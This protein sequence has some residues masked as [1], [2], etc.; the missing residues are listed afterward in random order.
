MKKKNI[1][2]TGSSSEIGIQ[3]ILDMAKY[4]DN[5]YAT[6]NKNVAQVN[7]LKSLLKKKKIK[8]VKFFKINFCNIKKVE[9]FAANFFQKKKINLLINNAA[10]IQRKKFINL[11]GNDWKN[12]LNCNLIAPFL[13]TKNA[14]IQKNTRT[15]KII[16]ISSIAAETGG[17]EQVHYAASKAGLTNLTKSITRLFSRKKIFSYSIHPG[18][19]FTKSISVSKKNK[20][21][22]LIKQIPIGR[23]GTPQ[24]VSELIKFLSNSST[25]YM[26]GS[27]LSINGGLR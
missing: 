24:E 15:L 19:I 25:E 5:I 22:K 1:L 23:L 27:T 26:T 16:N 9:K 7:K 11:S 17:I 10:I 2:I 18:V 20:S 13:L 3:I 4:S 14:I 8:N 21:S 12:I 6:Y